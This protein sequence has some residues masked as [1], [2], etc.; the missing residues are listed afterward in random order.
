M[1]GEGTEQH[2][3]LPPG[4]HRVEK[5]RAIRLPIDNA[6][7]LTPAGLTQQHVARTLA[8]RALRSNRRACRR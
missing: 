6:C 4:D 3:D 5:L 2:W 7:S 1:T 8:V